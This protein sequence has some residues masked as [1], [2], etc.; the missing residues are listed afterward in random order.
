M[1]FALWMKRTMDTAMP[2]STGGSNAGSMLSAPKF[3][4]AGPAAS[5][6]ALGLETADGVPF[7]AGA[8]RGKAVFLNYW[9][10]W[11]GPCRAE[12]PSI[13]RLYDKSRDLGVVFLLV[14]DEKPEKIRTY[15]QKNS[16]TMP[17]YRSTKG[18]PAALQTEGIPA[19]FI[20]A[21]D[22]RVSFSHV[23]AARWDDDSTL[24][25]L[26]SLPSPSTGRP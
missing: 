26:R 10:T 3:P 22:G 8:V 24:A 11:C 13:Q 15:L 18:R 25:F 17:V 1:L 4:A 21:S 16:F 14:S 20:L 9:A 12:M 23:G 7:D 2:G 6:F 5:D 19:T